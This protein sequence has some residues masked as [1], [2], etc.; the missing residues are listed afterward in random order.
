M[1]SRRGLGQRVLLAI[2]GAYRRWLSPLKRVP[3]CRYL[4][5]CSAYA[6]EAIVVHGALRG[7]WLAA[8]RV[9]RCSPLGG[10]GLDPVP[11]ALPAASLE[12]MEH[13]RPG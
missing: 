6:R 9:C 1:A 7:G 2:I 3:T 8:K 12:D 10:S 4:P 13:G 11:P 5:T